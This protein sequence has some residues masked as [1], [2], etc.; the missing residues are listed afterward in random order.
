MRIFVESNVSV[1]R[2]LFA[3]SPNDSQCTCTCTYMY[4]VY[5][6][7]IVYGIRRDKARVRG[8]KQILFAAHNVRVLLACHKISQTYYIIKTTSNRIDLS[9][10]PR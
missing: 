4:V 10:R 3:Q 1:R 8:D 7:N 9:S 2:C 6:R 5:V